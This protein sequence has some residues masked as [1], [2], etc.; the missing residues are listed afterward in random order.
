[1]SASTSKTPIVDNEKAL[2]NAPEILTPLR[3]HQPSPFNFTRSQ[4]S[5]IFGRS[6]SPFFNQSRWNSRE[7]TFRQPRPTPSDG[8]L[9]WTFPLPA[10]IIALLS[11][12][13]A[14]I[15]L[16]YL[17]AVRRVST[18][19]ASAIFVSEL[20][21]D[22]LVGLTISTV[23]THMVSISVP[24]L[25]YVAAYCV[26]GKWLQEQEFPG[27]TRPA[28]PT[29]LQYGFM[30][31][32]FTTSS[33]TSVFQAGQYMRAWR[34]T[35]Q[36]PRAFHLALTLTTLILGLSYSLI[37]ADIWLHGASSV[38]QVTVASA[39]PGVPVGLTFN[40]SVCTSPNNACLND[41]AGW[42]FNAPWVTQTGLRIA[43]NDTSAPFSVLTLNNASDLAVVVVPSSADLLLTADPD[44]M[45]SFGVRAQC[46]SLTPT[47]S[48]VSQ[49]QC[50]GYP[51][52]ALALG[53]N[54]TARASASASTHASSTS[55][56]HA[57]A[58]SAVPVPQ[59]TTSLVATGPAGANPQSVR[60]QLQWAPNAMV[61]PANPAAIQASSGD[62]L[63]WAACN[64]TFYNLTLRHEEGNYGVVGNP[65]LAESNFATI[66]QGGL[67]SQVGNLQL[68]SNLQ[69]T[70]LAQPDVSSAV[71][72]MNQELGRLT[73]ALFAGT[74]ERSVS[75]T[76]AQRTS[77]SPH[78][79]LLGRYPLPPV[80]V[81]L[82]LLYAYAL[83]AAGIYLA[84]AR[85]RSALFR[86]PGYK[87]TNAVQ[88][89]Q[90]RL[91]D[92]LALVAALYPSSHLEASSEAD[93]ARDLFLEDSTTPRLAMGTEGQA[94]DGF[95]SPR[96][97]A[98]S[99]FGVYRRAQP[100]PR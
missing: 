94:Q 3:K 4:S 97:A 76:A 55:A 47:C 59:P 61:R 73:L 46:S 38:V 99:V 71:A 81:Y 32:M 57:T 28:L 52:V 88:L 21:T 62:I 67:L 56:T 91:A 43:A 96:G 31:K 45:P 90:L 58:T 26:A 80:V 49:A 20:A 72:A 29:P 40:Q 74:L 65:V 8:T 69:A 84:A 100:V 82:L 22:T 5:P 89:A 54:T 39:V 92:P 15:L 35:I 1:M 44:S 13:M 34:P 36:F 2:P 11:F 93:D 78:P 86:A 70:M 42:A 25:I 18:P 77:I 79:V 53:G 60:V 23:A 64:L 19:D 48:A 68:L 24:F 9:R 37:L 98:R 66:M 85:L 17:V 51:Q 7:L 50:P 27:Q 33:V 63:A 10:L 83:T 75:P 95:T 14:T 41:T 16:L 12:T 87:Q 6:A 30:V